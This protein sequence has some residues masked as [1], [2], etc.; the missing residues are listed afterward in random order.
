VAVVIFALMPLNHIIPVRPIL[1]SLPHRPTDESWYSVSFD[2]PPRGVRYPA[3]YW[4]A[5]ASPS[6][7]ITRASASGFGSPSAV[8]IISSGI[9]H[10]NGRI[11]T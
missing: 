8:A 6:S 10:N 11:S 4:A 9:I 1:T 7:A 5:S 2:C 3:D